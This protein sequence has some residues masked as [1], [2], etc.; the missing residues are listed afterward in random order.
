MHLL[1][2]VAA[3]DLGLLLLLRLLVLLVLLR[4]LLFSRFASSSE[5]LQ[6]GLERVSAVH[7]IVDVERRSSLRSPAHLLSEHVTQLTE[8]PGDSPGEVGVV[9]M[10]LLPG[11]TLALSPPSVFRIESNPVS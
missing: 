3:I 6:V 10:G 7:G 5:L 2:V 11:R 4:L 8:L 1:V 9:I